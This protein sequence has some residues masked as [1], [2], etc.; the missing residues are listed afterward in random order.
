MRLFPTVLSGCLLAF[1]ASVGSA[2]QN[3]PVV[4]A[5]ILPGQF[6]LPPRP[7]ASCPVSLNVGSR[8]L[9][10]LSNAENQTSPKSMTPAQHIQ[11]GLRNLRTREVVSIDAHVQGISGVP[12][13]DFM[14]LHPEDGTLDRT[15]SGGTTPAKQ[16]D[17]A[18]DRLLA[19][20]PFHASLRLAANAQAS[21]EW[22]LKNVG[23][24]EWV[25]IDR[26]VYADGSEWQRLHAD[27]C[28]I[29]PNPLVLVK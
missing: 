5:A 10:Y 25:Q 17:Q 23:G 20:A 2:Q 19:P 6:Q 4:S 13:L 12:H 22:T 14:P 21:L 16:S 15:G 1:A 26:I 11:I 8:S 7:D 29:S 27:S 24:I 18:K 28:K 9:V 3:A